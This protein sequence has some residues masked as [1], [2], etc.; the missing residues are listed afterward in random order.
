MFLT[1][2][3]SPIGAVKYLNDWRFRHATAAPKHRCDG[4]VTPDLPL[5]KRKAC[6]TR[7]LQCRIPHEV[8]SVSPRKS[9][10]PSLHH[11]LGR[12]VGNTN[13]PPFDTAP[14]H[15]LGPLS[16]ARERLESS[17]LV[18]NPSQRRDLGNT[19]TPVPEGTCPRMH[20]TAAIST[21][22]LRTNLESVSTHSTNRSASDFGG[23]ASDKRLFR[24]S[25]YNCSGN[26]AVQFPT[27]GAA[28]S[29]TTQSLKKSSRAIIGSVIRSSHRVS[30]SSG[31]SLN[32]RGGP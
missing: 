29:S 8:H 27:S 15:F 12:S 6:L 25:L 22:R 32:R 3:G 23:D 5:T 7:D 11:L 21:M 28:R 31:P 20:N 26:T 1:F 9:T 16:T 4:S 19:S 17:S 18:L 10:S 14:Q 2:R 30:F 13:T 24:Y